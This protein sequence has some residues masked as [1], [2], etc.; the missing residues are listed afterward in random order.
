MPTPPPI[1]TGGGGGFGGPGLADALSRY[2][3][4]VQ[5]ARDRLR[6][7]S[8]TI[9][10]LKPPAPIKLPPPPQPQTTD[11]MGAFGSAAMALAGLGS[12]MTRQPLINAL[13]AG[14]AVM[15]AYHQNDMR[16]AQLQFQQWQTAVRNAE[17]M[18]RFEQQAYTAALAKARLQPEVARAELTTLAASFKDNVVHS[19]VSRGDLSGAANVIMGRGK[20]LHSMTNNAGEVSY[21]EQIA[22]KIRA[23]QA[24]GDT[25][26]VQALVHEYATHEFERTG[27][28]P[29]EL[30]KIAGVGARPADQFKQQR[31]EAFQALEK[32]T[33]AGDQKGVDAAKKRIEDINLAEG[34]KTASVVKKDAMPPG[35]RI[36]AQENLIHATNALDTGD[37]L[38]HIMNTTPFAVGVGG[39]VGRPVEAIG[40]LIGTSE[41]ARSEFKR[42]LDVLRIEYASALRLSGG[43]PLAAEQKL[44]EEIVGGRGWGE[45]TKNVAD[46]IRNIQNDMYKR[47]QYLEAELNGTWTPDFRPKEL[48]SIAWKGAPAAA[49]T[50]GNDAGYNY[51]SYTPVRPP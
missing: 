42:R 45:T 1:S 2:Q 7:V 22:Q 41:T 38:L 17:T 43:R 5:D 4:G 23:A 19:M 48:P 44:I 6:G 14:A 11:F 34:K 29:P 30:T 24:A 15:N 16:E 9:D 40:N 8:A 49:D 27:K 47:R 3:A 50:G 18:Q 25:G 51:E 20:A 13:N 28:I 39:M 21:R 31:L 35:K 33:A 26:A 10:N 46:A 37:Q 32:A 12:L 36:D